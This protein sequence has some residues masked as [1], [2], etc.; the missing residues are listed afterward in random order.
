MSLVFNYAEDYSKGLKML[1]HVS[2]HKDGSVSMAVSC[3]AVRLVKP[4]DE[5]P[6]LHESKE[7]AKVELAKHGEKV[8]K[9]SRETQLRRKRYHG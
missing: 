4:L 7:L 5:V 1:V 8:F 3:G 9:V 2:R 6:T